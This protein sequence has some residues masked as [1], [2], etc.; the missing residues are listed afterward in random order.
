MRVKRERK[1]NKKQT[2]S[3]P[4]YLRQGVFFYV[5][6]VTKKIPLSCKTTI[7]NANGTYVILFDQACEP[8]KQRGFTSLSMHLQCMALFALLV[9]GSCLGSADDGVPAVPQAR[10]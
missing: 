4:F 2:P 3:T 6:F 9:H 1:T 5:S 8:H 10:C 7:V